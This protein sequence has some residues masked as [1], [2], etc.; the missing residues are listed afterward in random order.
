MFYA[1]WN[2]EVKGWDTD[3][4]GE[5]PSL[6]QCVSF[7]WQE[8]GRTTVLKCGMRVAMSGSQAPATSLRLRDSAVPVAG[9]EGGRR[10]SPG[11]REGTV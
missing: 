6:S 9:G 4:E 1:D 5:L 10:Q 7:L 8:A 2:R 3:A 11:R